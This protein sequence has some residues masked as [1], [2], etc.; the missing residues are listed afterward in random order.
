MAVK[1]SE[2]TKLN[3][4]Q[5]K[6]QGSNP[7][8][9]ASGFG[10]LFVKSDGV[11]FKNSAG[12]VTGPFVASGGGLADP[13]TLAK[14][15]TP[16]T[17]AADHVTVF[18]GDFNGDARLQV[19][20]HDGSVFTVPFKLTELTDTPIDLTGKAGKALIVNATEDG[21]DIAP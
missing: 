11:Y 2:T 12:V 16:A 19:E 1:I 21:F 8:S 17:P 4:A 6:V 20:H 9:P 10:Y 13:P 14:R 18:V 5:F 3:K 15:S 7:S